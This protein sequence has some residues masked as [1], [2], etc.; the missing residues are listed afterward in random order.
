MTLQPCKFKN[1]FI[2]KGLQ[3]LNDGCYCEKEWRPS[4]SLSMEC[5]A[6][7]QAVAHCASTHCAHTHGGAGVATS[8]VAAAS[9][10][11][12]VDAGQQWFAELASC[13]QYSGTALT[14]PLH[15]ALQHSFRSFVPPF[16]N[17]KPAPTRASAL[18]PPACTKKASINPYVVFC[19]EQRPLLPRGLRNAEREQTLG[20]RIDCVDNR[21]PQPVSRLAVQGTSAFCVPY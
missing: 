14:S 16:D 13:A 4:I 21:V 18:A 9:P 7:Q 19:R 15:D 8:S 6:Q 12:W 5:V 20:M 3:C 2:G 17:Y 10:F 1:R 11:S